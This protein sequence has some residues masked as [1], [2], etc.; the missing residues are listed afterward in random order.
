MAICFSLWFVYS[1]K[2][3]GVSTK[4]SIL[5][6]HKLGKVFFLPGEGLRSET[7]YHRKVN[8]VLLLSVHT[9]V[10]TIGMKLCCIT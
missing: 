9:T 6:K 7:L 10:L 1:T 5:V 3:L 8:A 4:K 2:R